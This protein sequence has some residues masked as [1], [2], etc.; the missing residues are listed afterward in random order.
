[1]FATV[2]IISLLHCASD[3]CYNVLHKSLFMSVKNHCYIALA[4]SATVLACHMV[5]SLYSCSWVIKITVILRN[6]WL[7][8]RTP[9][10]SLL[11]CV[12]VQEYPKSLLCCVTHDCYSAQSVISLL[13]CISVT[14]YQISLLCWQ[15]HPCYNVT[16]EISLLHCIAVTSYRKSLSCC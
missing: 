4:M 14:V 3:D 1:M 6:I 15:Y 9:V 10:I 2:C 7:L 8:Q 12:A 13:D 5:A 16:C 11:H